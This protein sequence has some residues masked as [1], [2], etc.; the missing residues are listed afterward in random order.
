MSDRLRA[1]DL[2]RVRGAEEILSTL[3]ARGCLD[4]MPF[5]PEMLSYC[6]KT[7]R[8]YKRA[9][10]T[11]DTI[12]RY[13]ARR[14]EHTVHLEEA[15]CTGGAHGGCE[16]AC[17][18]FWNEAW[19]ERAAGPH[20][21]VASFAAL[22]APTPAQGC[23]MAQLLGAT[24][25]GVDPQQGIRYRCQ[26]TDLLNATQPLSRVNWRQYVE[27]YRSGNV[28]LGTLGRG[29][30]YR[31]G[32]FV[33]R[34]WQRLGRKLGFGEVL[35]KPLIACYDAV[36]ALVPDGVPYPR[37]YGQVAK[38]Q[39]TPTDGADW[40][41]PGVRVRVKSYREIL[42]TLDINSKT[43]GLYFDAEMVP[44]CGKELPVRSVV[45]Q[46]VDE[47]TGYML[48]FKT[49]AAILESAYCRGTHSDNRMFCP[50]AIY[51]YWRTIWLTPL[52]SSAP[53]GAHASAMA[54]RLTVVP[55]AHSAQCETAADQAGP[56]RRQGEAPGRERGRRSACN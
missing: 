34:P 24:Q 33:V 7:L 49:P 3:D 2:V 5:M 29:A 23:S 9:H 6:G 8:V 39:P 45:N 11:C 36:Q 50:R 41:R 54:P 12:S 22:R 18:L 53:V 31:L 20:E 19:L 38:G 1:G 28:T 26:A 56:Q 40:L 10:K 17:M 43:R 30:L 13:V 44:Y 37:R 25:H 27:D 47:R 4:G 14:L 15:R 55:C 16:A 42:S 21:G 46:I 52:E 35:A 51:P 32:T 48:R